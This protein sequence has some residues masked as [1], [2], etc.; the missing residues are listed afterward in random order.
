LIQEFEL[1]T[2][3]YL[4]TIVLQTWTFSAI[5][6]ERVGD[7]AKGGINNLDACETLP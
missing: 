7:L 3:N 2:N 1:E 5:L 6:L 4:K